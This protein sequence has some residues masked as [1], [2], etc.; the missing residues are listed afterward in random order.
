MHGVGREGGEADGDV[1][2]T[3]RFGR[4]VADPLA[5]GRHNCLTGADVEGATIVFD[6]KQPS[7]DDGDF[8]KLRSLSRLGPT[9]R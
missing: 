2:S 4:A 7:Q 8:F 5:G 3:F 6:S 1:L 9:G